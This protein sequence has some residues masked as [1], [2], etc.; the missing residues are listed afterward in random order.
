[1]YNTY[2]VFDCQD[3]PDDTRRALFD[4]TEAANDCYIAWYIEVDEEFNSEEVQ[5]VTDWLLKNG[6]HMSDESVIVKHWW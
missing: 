1:M 4:C 5:L 6:A 3:M 2:K